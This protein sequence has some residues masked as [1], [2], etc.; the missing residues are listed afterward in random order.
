M[1]STTD[2]AIAAPFIV[3]TTRS[4]VSMLRQSMSAL[5]SPLMSAMRTTCQLRGTLPMKV[6]DVMDVPLISETTRSPLERSRHRMPCE[7]VPAKSP[8]PAICHRTGTFAT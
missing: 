2:E 5:P 4:P 7:P 3:N 8:V 1:A 6:E